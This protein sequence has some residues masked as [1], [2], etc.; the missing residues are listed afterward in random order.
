MENQL[1]MI[2][3]IVNN[4]GGVGKTTTVQNLAAGMLRKNKKLKI[5]EIDLDPQ[6]NLT[7]LNHSPEGC[8]T[9]FESMVECKGMPIYKS[10]IGIYYVPGAAKMQDIDPF[11]QNTGAPRQ[12]LGACINSDCVDMTGEGIK[13][14]IDFFDY[15]FIDCPPA[16]SQSTY[17]AMVVASHLLVPVQME[18]LSVNGLAAI[19]GAMEEV[20]NGRFALNQDLELLGLLPVMVDER[21][22]IVRQAIQYLKD[23]YGRKVIEHGIRRCIKVNEAQT[24]MTDLFHYAPY[25]TA[26]NDYS[27]VIKEIFGI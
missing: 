10:D 17:N 5:L 27:A 7:L 3:A 11:L 16:L 18:G 24:E 20:K 13:N 15:I 22:R 9:I 12:V 21:P 19:L 4:K 2:L 6:C 14:P 8:A 25:C 23:T 1:K 26:A